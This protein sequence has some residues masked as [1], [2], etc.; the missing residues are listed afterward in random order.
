MEIRYRLRKGPKITGY[1]RRM[2][3]SKTFFFSKDQFWWNGSEIDHDQIDEAIGLRDINNRPIY[4]LDIVIYKIG[5]GVDRQGAVLWSAERDCFL[6]KDFDDLDLYIP[7]QVEGL[8]LFESQ[9]LRF[10]AFL[11]THPE[12]MKELGVRDE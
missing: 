8:D 3:G 9:D 5:D 10:H 7:L 1:M 6:I 11:F 12:L 2:K 4:E